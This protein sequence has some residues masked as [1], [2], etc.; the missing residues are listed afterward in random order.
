MNNRSIYTGLVVIG[1]VAMLGG[2]FVYRQYYM[3]TGNLQPQMADA[4]VITIPAGGD[5]QAAINSASLGDE[6]VLEAGA[7]Y[8]GNFTLPYKSSGSGYITIR[9]SNLD[10]L[11]DEGVR[12]SPS[13]AAN[14]PKLVTP[15][16]MP[17]FT[18][19]SGANPSH[20]YKLIGLEITRPDNSN[21]VTNL[22]NF[23]GNHDTPSEVP[24][25]FVIDRN[26]IHGHDNSPTR[27]GIYADGRNIEMTNNY[28]SKMHEPGSD[29]Q[30]IL[31]INGAKDLVIRN[32]FLE[33]A[34]ENIM[35]GGG[36]AS[37]ADMVPSDI[38]IEYNHFYKPE[39][40]RGIPYPNNKVIKNLFE[41]KSAKRLIIQNN[42]F[43]NS[44]PEAQNGTGILF[45]TRNQYGGAPWSQVTDI[46]FRYNII[47]RVGNGISILASDYTHPSLSSH[48]LDI[49]NNLFLIDPTWAGAQGMAFL[50]QK[51][52]AAEPANNVAITHNTVIH[53]E[54]AGYGNRMF[55]FD[56]SIDVFSDFNYSNNI[57]A[58]VGDL[59]YIS[60]NGTNGVT[61]LNH[62]LAEPYNFLN[63]IIRGS[64]GPN[65][66]N[67]FY[68][69]SN[70][71]IGFENYAGNI[72]KLSSSSTYKNQATDGTDPGVNWD[73]LMA[74]TANV[75]S[76]SGSGGGE[77]TPPSDTTPP[78]M[79]NTTS[80]GPLAA[81]TVSTNLTLT[82]NE[83]ATCKY[84]TAASQTYAAKPNTFT[85]TGS[86]SHS[87]QITGLTN[88]QSYTYRVRCQDS[89][90]NP[91]TSD[92]NITFSVSAPAG[93]TT[94][95]VVSLTAPANNT[96]V[97]G[98]SVAVSA[99][100]TDNV[101]VV[102]VQF[103]LNG[104]NLGTEDTSS[105]YSIT[106]NTTTAANGTHSITATARDAAGN[107]TTS[108]A[109]TVTVS[110]VTPQ[111]TVATPTISPNGGSFT[112]SQTVTLASATGGASIY[113]TT[114]GSD[115]TASSTLYSSPFS[116][117]ATS[118]VKAIGIKS[119]STNSSISSATFTITIPTP[120]STGGGGG[121]GGGSS[122]PKTPTTPTGVTLTSGDSFICSGSP[123][124]YYYYN[125]VKEA[126]AEYAVWLA[127]NGPSFA[128]VKTI[129]QTECDLITYNGLARLPE[130][131]YIKTTT[132]QE[133]YRTEGT[134]ARPY[135]NYPAFLRDSQGKQIITITIPYLHSYSRGANIE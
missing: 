69:A 64:Q 79:T 85:S 44:W 104:S 125:G 90:G 60:Q 73:E 135:T 67:N 36:D 88:G 128:N 98:A 68:A 133:V 94:D 21:Q 109:R 123:T 76:G 56:Q 22:I 43:E 120:P 5:L 132:G 95:P 63:N 105:P 31:G 25:D 16:N 18:T 42:I 26:Y 72:F 45:T 3:T 116:I 50:L 37:S 106:W 13:D 126:Y 12:V 34:S 89:A 114:N 1:L 57:I 14:M 62:A 102:G 51:D 49:N 17:V 55:E 54:A 121:G 110:N 66:P 97:S 4:A 29:S 108:T 80:A 77:P 134:T 118:T 113:Y 11:P 7:T 124:V 19:V 81:G 127:W 39:S 41:L 20:H 112:S 52:A 30:A 91:N 35:F 103:K 130:G 82:T 96:T 6:I 131:S 83:S 24:H 70:D 119:G 15:T 129:S 93:D 99:T 107:T 38:L 71:A 84:G 28:I 86:T 47:K 59:G 92:L 23:N 10:Q 100:A 53:R 40:W 78:V 87:T 27:R 111:D 117:S 9:S 33:A 48:N 61:A 32:N 101:A 75:V 115:P 122:K 8:T 65:P 46:T 74:R 2:A 58:G